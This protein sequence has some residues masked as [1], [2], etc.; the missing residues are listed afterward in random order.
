[1]YLHK[2]FAQTCP[3]TESLSH[4]AIEPH[5]TMQPREEEHSGKKYFKTEKKICLVEKE[6]FT[7]MG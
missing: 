2:L 3:L 7:T 6:I 5:P 1:M 4:P